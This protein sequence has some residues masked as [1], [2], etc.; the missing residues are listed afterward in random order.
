MLLNAIKAISWCFAN[1]DDVRH[2][3]PRDGG[4]LLELRVYKPVNFKTAKFA[5]LH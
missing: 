4:A 3:L 1:V 2:Y 5:E